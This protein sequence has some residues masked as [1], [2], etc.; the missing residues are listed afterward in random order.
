MPKKKPPKAPAF[1][2]DAEFQDMDTSVL[3]SSLQTFR[4]RFNEM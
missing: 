2:I 4:E 3:K 1:I